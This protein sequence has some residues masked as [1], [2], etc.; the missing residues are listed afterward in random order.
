MS[1]VTCAAVRKKK[2]SEKVTRM[3]KLLIALIA[4]LYVSALLTFALPNR[5]AK[6]PGK[7]FLGASVNML[8]PADGNFKEIYGSQRTFPGIKAGFFFS[9]GFYLWGSCGF[10]SGSG[11]IDIYGT[12]MEAK[13]KQRFISFGPGYSAALAG[14]INYH[15]EA[16]AVSFT[17]E[18]EAMETKVS[19]SSFGVAINLGVSYH[20]G[21]FFY[22]DIFTT[23]M[24]DS[25]EQA[26]KIKLGGVT[27]GIG[28]GMRF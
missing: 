5:E 14:R 13:T 19:A 8:Q 27:A 20:F 21:R 1:R 11:E 25:T 24:A 3:R 22:A 7:F 15:L 10:F 28:V 16:G 23:Y 9:K 6:K 18:E 4:L 26:R 12:K 2:R 17:Y